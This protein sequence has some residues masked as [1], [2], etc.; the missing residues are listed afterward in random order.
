MFLQKKCRR[1]CPLPLQQLMRIMNTE[2]IAW[3]II[4][5]VSVLCLFPFLVL[6]Q[7]GM[8]LNQ[9]A[10]FFSGCVLSLVVGA[11]LRARIGGIISWLVVMSGLFLISLHACGPAQMMQ[12][13]GQA[14][15]ST[16]IGF[17]IT[18]LAIGQLRSVSQRKPLAHEGLA[19]AHAAIQEQALTD[20]LTGLPNHGTIIERIEAEL[21]QCQSSQRNC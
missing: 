15:F 20:G 1:R 16:G 21:L 8:N 11:G 18:A 4:F 14:L 10:Q 3:G 19:K 5:L 9:S 7:P 2:P 17:L 13:D 6:D 12:T